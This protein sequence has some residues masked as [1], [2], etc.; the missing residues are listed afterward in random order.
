MSAAAARR[1]KQLALRATN[2]KGS[3]NASNSNDI[4]MEQL[5][6][7][8]SVE[9]GASSVLS[10]EVAYEALQL[11]QSSVRKR[12]QQC[13]YVDGCDLAYSTSLKLL[14]KGRV[15]VASQ[16]LQLL[17]D[18]LRETHTEE[19]PEWI[20]RI[21]ELHTAHQ[22][23]MKTH[24]AT[25]N[26]EE[27]NRL[28]RLQRSW[29][30]LLLKWSSELGTTQY[31]HNSIHELLG[32]QC[33]EVSN[34]TATDIV[35]DEEDCMEM[36]CDAIQHMALAEQPQV[37]LEWL[38]QLPPPTPEQV[39][40]GHD[41]PPA[42]RDMLLTRAVLLLC[43]VQNLRD[44]NT[45]VRTYMTTIEERPLVQLQK[46]YTLKDDGLAPS[47]LIFCTMLCRIC[48][49]DARTGPLYQWLL[50]SFKRELDLFYKPQA[51]QSYHTKIG[52]LYFNI[53]APPSMLKMMESMMGGGGGMGGMGGMGGIDPA[54]M[55][56]LMASMGGGRM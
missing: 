55:Q 15:S 29:L 23:A 34:E 31:G 37:I 8:L 35:M 43:A 2:A 44:A 5:D 47:H 4:V 28:Q 26:T 9:D 10:E 22:N 18:I 16:L 19:T 33:W 49:K 27:T 46:S 40:A 17:A 14:Q 11:A 48:E 25:A 30:L 36:K 53:E 13:N 38:K 12:I 56:N 50:K 39:A 41:S 42:I 52:K 24:Y 32:Y 45:M 20:A 3:D 51:I 7:L 6:K 21:V 1:K 54:M